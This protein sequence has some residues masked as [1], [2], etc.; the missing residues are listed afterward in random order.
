MQIS[1]GIW[2]HQVISLSGL[3]AEMQYFLCFPYAKWQTTR[4]FADGKVVLAGTAEF[5]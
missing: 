2:M 5:H 4:Y 1:L 3:V